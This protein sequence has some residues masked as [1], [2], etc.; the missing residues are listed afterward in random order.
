LSSGG[1]NIQNFKMQHC[2]GGGVK[3]KRRRRRRWRR[4]VVGK[5][6]SVGL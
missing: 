5:D 3:K 4:V 2:L 6:V 1:D